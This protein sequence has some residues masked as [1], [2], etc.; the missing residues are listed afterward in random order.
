[1]LPTNPTCDLMP[2]VDPTLRIP[3][4]PQ[5][6]LLEADGAGGTAGYLF[7]RDWFWEANGRIL[8]QESLTVS[9]GVTAT[10]ST[11]KGW[12][13]NAQ[14]GQSH[15]EFRANDIKTLSKA[16]ASASDEPGT[17][18]RIDVDG[19]S[20]WNEDPSTGQTYTTPISYPVAP[21]SD[22]HCRP[23]S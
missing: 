3:P 17:C 21:H 2:C 6:Q 4:D 12:V 8:C 14:K 15:Q 5:C 23:G 11:A 22:K 1:M 13:G 10:P 18:I 19:T 9:V 7:F 16:T 20:V